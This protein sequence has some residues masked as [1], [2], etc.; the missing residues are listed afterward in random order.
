M[1]RRWHELLYYEDI[2]DIAVGVWIIEPDTEADLGKQASPRPISRKHNI[3]IHENLLIDFS[4]HGQ[5]DVNNWPVVIKSINDKVSPFLF[6][7]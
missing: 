7:V 1:L 4:G 3:F 2:E 6:Q 5:I